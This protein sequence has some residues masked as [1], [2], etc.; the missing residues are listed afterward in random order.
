[1]TGRVVVVGLGPG[2]PALVSVAAR[3]AIEASPLRFV[4]TTRHPS[5]QLVEPALS[6]DHLYESADSIEEVYAG[7]VAALVAGALTEDVLYAVPGSPLVAERTVELLRADGR[8]AVEVI[9][10][11]SFLDLCWARIGIDPVIAGICLVDGHRFAEAAAGSAG[12]FLVGQCDSRMVLSDLKLAVDDGPTVTVLQ[13]LGL[14]DEAVFDVAWAE[15]DREVEPDHLTSVYIP[16]MAAPVAAELT[17]FAELVRT[18]RAGCPWD[19]E[20]THQSLARH[21]IEE[22]YEVLDAI[23]AL[24]R[25]DGY[26]H[27]EEELGDLLFQIAFHSTLAAEA[28]EFDLTDVARGIHDKLV[29]RHPHLFGPP[30]TEQP[31]WEEQKRAEK[32]RESVMDGVPGELPSLLY[33]WK[34]QSKAASVGFDWTN[35]DQVWPKVGEEIDEL[36][37]ALREEPVDG[38]AV[39]DELGDVLFSVVNLS[40]HLGVDPELALRAATGKFATRFRA[41][42]ILARERGAAVDDDLWEEV[43]SASPRR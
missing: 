9:P 31:N 13:R 38:H 21:L 3:E 24:D 25:G 26:E 36:R 30:G 32:G 14:P 33:A 22:S 27:L 40:R 17:R 19:R 29:E 28:G 7:I 42:E 16:A 1:V 10:S 11:L 2:D 34:V 39:N 43:K 18:L 37:A 4:R 8:V 20:Q 15:L 41:M 5:A 23:A 12:P 35:V 6:F